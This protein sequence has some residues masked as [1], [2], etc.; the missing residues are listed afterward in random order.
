MRKSVGAI[1][2]AETLGGNQISSST[3][4]LLLERLR[5]AD[6]LAGWQEFLLQYSSV[7]YQT[8]RT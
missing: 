8:V 2:P 4:T 5:S 6:A 1:A 7:L 3:V